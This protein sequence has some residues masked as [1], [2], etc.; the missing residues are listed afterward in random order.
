M[1]A[2]AWTRDSAEGVIS[3][4]STTDIPEHGWLT[5]ARQRRCVVTDI[6]RSLPVGGA[7]LADDGRRFT[8]GNPACLLA[9]SYHRYAEEGEAGPHEKVRSE[10]GS[11]AGKTRPSLPRGTDRCACFESASVSTM[12]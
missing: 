9:L 2:Q 8:T 11:V 5:Q 7:L 10:A 1:Q 3:L 12:Q 4:E 6:A